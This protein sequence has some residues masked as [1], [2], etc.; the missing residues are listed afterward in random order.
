MQSKRRCILHIPAQGLTN[1][2]HV[3]HKP[4]EK[5]GEWREPSVFTSGWFDAPTIWHQNPRGTD[6]GQRH[7]YK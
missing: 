4:I 3:L 2:E 5:P 1:V 7:Q 6:A